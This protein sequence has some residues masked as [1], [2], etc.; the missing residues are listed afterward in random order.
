M[1]AKWMNRLRTK[2][3]IL[4]FYV[5]VGCATAI[6]LAWAIAA[7]TRPTW[8]RGPLF[9]RTIASINSVRWLCDVERHWGVVI[10]LSAREDRMKEYVANLERLGI[11]APGEVRAPRWSRPWGDV[12]DSGR[13]LAFVEVAFGWPCAALRYDIVHRVGDFTGP[14]GP[15]GFQQGHS[16]IVVEGSF[17]VP[18]PT[19]N[20]PSRM[21]FPLLP[22]WSGLIA[23][24]SLSSLG[25]FFAVKTVKCLRRRVR[26]GRG[27]CPACGYHL[28]AR[29]T[30][31]CS[32][33]GW[34]RGK[35]GSG[36]RLSD[37]V[38]RDSTP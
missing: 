24:V 33:C 30:Y 17:S 9:P 25:W 16:H 23:N 20:A 26:D 6:G 34:G 22:I 32:E 12:K 38:R 21:Q 8:F 10:V 36:Q 19:T 13:D 7:F 28:G 1:T 3:I 35:G 4:L 11:A 37:P 27:L 29:V 31:G 2:L 5:G 18:G 15:S 14:F